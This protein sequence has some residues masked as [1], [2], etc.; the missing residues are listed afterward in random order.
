MS[1]KSLDLARAEK[2]FQRLLDTPENLPV[3][4]VYGGKSYHGMA[5]V[6]LLGNS[7]TRCATGWRGEV[8]FQIDENLE[9]KVGVAYCAEFGQM[10]YTGYFTNTGKENSGQLEKILAVDLEFEGANPVLRGCLG[11][12]QN[13]YKAYERDIAQRSEYFCSTG[14]RATHVLFPY[15]D[16]VHGDGGTMIA[17]G[18]AGTWS[19]LFAPV[20]GATRM[21]AQTCNDIC[22]V[23]R[24]G[25]SIR[26]GLV[27]LLPYRGR[28]A[29][30][31]GNLWREWWLKY[32]QPR[33]NAQGDPIQPFSTTCFAAD[34]GLPNSDGSISE[35]YSTWKPTLDKLIAEDVAPDFR[36]FDAGWYCDANGETVP[37][38]W[39]ATVGTWELDP[40]KWPGTSFRESNDACHAAGLK[41][42]TWFEPERVTDV[43]ALARNYGYKSEWG[44]DNGRGVVTSNIGD[45]ECLAWTLERIV[46]MMDENAV[47]LYREDNNSDPE[48]SWRIL[49]ERQSREYGI[50]RCGLNENF[51]IQGHYRLW[52]AIL[53]NSAGQGKF[54]FLDSCASGGGRNDIESLRRSIPLLRS[55]FDRTTTAL[56]LSMTASFCRWV[57][58]HGASTK[59]TRDQLEDLVGAGS[60]SYVNRA[61]LLPVYNIAGLAFTHNKE[62]DF[63]L[64]RRNI[65][66]WKSVRHLLCKDLYLLT[67]W[68]HQL[69]RF[70]WMSVAYDDPEHGETLLLAFRQEDCATAEFTARLS[71]LEP[72]AV[73][74][75]TDDDTGRREKFSGQELIRGFAIRLDRPRSSALLRIKRQAE[76]RI[77]S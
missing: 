18:W 45:P 23:L 3:S 25:E 49:D 29:N 75:V 31:A 5:G 22:A 26:T 71:F 62:I 16:L 70:G 38:Q 50:P 48:A 67:P 30:D 24:P 66:E 72:Y 19:A 56:R 17:L 60:D 69:D 36:W 12:L 21:Q 63:E 9:L 13:Y 57:P 10:E 52:D 37:E 32:N 34:T 33:A 43:E 61:S 39:W 8:R 7:V 35:R 6:P 2:L 4:F 11:D 53:A 27:V 58:F 65:N 46:K 68:H 14:G 42:L 64:L 55:D 40:V 74:E 76:R 15:F 20:A 44:V 73:Y 59:E 47:D 41:V 77:L 28:D 54:T 51:C 1:K